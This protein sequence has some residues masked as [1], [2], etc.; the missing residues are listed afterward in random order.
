MIPVDEMLSDLGDILDQF[1]A[2]P[3]HDNFALIQA[4]TRRIESVCEDE[5][6]EA[7]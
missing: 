3:S 6:P 7:A 5:L 1:A 2:D 4:E